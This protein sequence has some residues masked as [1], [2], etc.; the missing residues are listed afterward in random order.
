MEQ[1]ILYN[2]QNVRL[3][4]QKASTN[5][6][7]QPGAAYTSTAIPQHLTSYQVRQPV[8]NG[9]GGLH[10]TQQY[11]PRAIPRIQY[12]DINHQGY[13]HQHLTGYQVRQPIQNGSGVLHTTQQY[14]PRAIPQIQYNEI[15][16]QGHGRQHLTGYQVRQGVQSGSGVLHTT[17]QYDPRACCEMDSV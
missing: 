2:S 1:T 17:Q 5:N 6:L 15:N 8:Q 16:H 12:N 3:S 13:G 7:L 14:D 4:N 11:D 10:T 9:S